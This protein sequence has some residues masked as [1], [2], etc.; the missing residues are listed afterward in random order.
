MTITHSEYIANFSSWNYSPVTFMLDILKICFVFF[1]QRSSFNDY[2]TTSITDGFL[3]CAR[4]NSECQ[5]TDVV[6][7]FCCGAQIAKSIGS[8]DCYEV[9]VVEAFLYWK[10]FIWMSCD[11]QVW[12][13]ISFILHCFLLHDDLMSL[14]LVLQ[15]TVSLFCY[16]CFIHTY[17]ILKTGASFRLTAWTWCL[18][19][20]SIRIENIFLD[21]GTTA[22]VQFARKYWQQLKTFA[23]FSV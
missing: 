12:R 2:K 6:D 8:G 5:T 20:K 7:N 4:G 23:W 17:Y 21:F 9:V 19:A 1:L 14:C 10:Q 22:K 15:Y 16:I 18:F 3:Q 13:S 11:C